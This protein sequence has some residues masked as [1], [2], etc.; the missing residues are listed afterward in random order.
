MLI[1]PR[2]TKRKLNAD[3]FCLVRYFGQECKGASSSFW[4]CKAEDGNPRNVALRRPFVSLDPVNSNGPGH[5]PNLQ[6][7]VRSAFQ[8]IPDQGCMPRCVSD[9]KTMLPSQVHV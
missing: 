6:C 2:R 8:A 9:I 1:N 3:V 5:A 4:Q 7:F